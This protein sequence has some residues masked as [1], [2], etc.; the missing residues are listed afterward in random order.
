MSQIDI[1]AFAGL[2]VLEVLQT[3]RRPPLLIRTA[4]IGTAD[5]RRTRD[6][7]RLLRIVGELP[8]PVRALELLLEAEARLDEQ[9]RADDGCYDLLRHVGVMI[10][11]LCEARLLPRP[12]L[13]Q[14]PLSLQRD[15]GAGPA[16]L[17]LVS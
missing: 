16:R 12:A 1:A 4:R 14:K 17:R 3:L 10:A 7:R 9:R 11:I 15:T 13:P 8:G 6:L 2:D 5:Y